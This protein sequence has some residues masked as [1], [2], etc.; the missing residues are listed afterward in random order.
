M[1]PKDPNRR[2]QCAGFLFIG[3]RSWYSDPEDYTDWVGFTWNFIDFTR[4]LSAGCLPA[5][6]IVNVE[7]YVPMVVTR[8]P[9]L[10]DW[11]V[12]PIT[13]YYTTLSFAEYPIS[14]EMG[15]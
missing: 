12:V 10:E 13:D 6:L 3:N 7:D 2:Y 9:G 14:Q 1:T 4:D 15:V 5:G 11:K 8:S